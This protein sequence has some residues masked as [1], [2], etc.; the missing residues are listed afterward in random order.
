MTLQKYKLSLSYIEAF[1]NP[2]G[3]LIVGDLEHGGKAAAD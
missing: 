2:W 1:V 3:L